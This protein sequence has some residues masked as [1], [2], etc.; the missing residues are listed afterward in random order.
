MTLFSPSLGK[1]EI[2]LLKITIK[3]DNTITHI[4]KKKILSIEN[5]PEADTFIIKFNENDPNLCGIMFLSSKANRFYLLKSHNEDI[6]LI[7]IYE[8]QESLEDF[9]WLNLDEPYILLLNTNYE[10]KAINMTGNKISM[11]MSKKSSLVIPLGKQINIKSKN[12]EY[13]NIFN[14]DGEV[15][16]FKNI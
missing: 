6:D 7:S 11:C 8:D 2:V 15:K 9:A 14:I 5:D 10:L 13:Q 4:I 1:I 3:P 12:I 16:S